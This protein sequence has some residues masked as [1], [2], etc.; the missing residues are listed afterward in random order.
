MA[1]D[2]I[3]TFYVTLTFILTLN[4]KIFGLS[5]DYNMRQVGSLY[6]KWNKCYDQKCSF[7]LN[8]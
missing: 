3:L 5:I 2:V 4:V 7:D 1:K 6:A 8:L